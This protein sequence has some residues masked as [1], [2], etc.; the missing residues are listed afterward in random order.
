MSILNRN[1]ASQKIMSD[2]FKV[3]TGKKTNKLSI[4]NCI[5]SESVF[6]KQWEKGRDVYNPTTWE[7]EAVGL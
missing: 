2:I 6:Q 4:Q 3:L 7:T 5:T 1:L